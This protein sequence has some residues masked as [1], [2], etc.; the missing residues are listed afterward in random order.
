MEPKLGSQVLFTDADRR[1]ILFLQGSASVTPAPAGVASRQ[2]RRSRRTTEGR[3]R[4][5]IGNPQSLRSKSVQVRGRNL[6]ACLVN[7]YDLLWPY[8]FRIDQLLELWVFVGYYQNRCP[9]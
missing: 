3:G 4:I 2:N 8:L 9:S 1:I 7:H 5:E 6:T